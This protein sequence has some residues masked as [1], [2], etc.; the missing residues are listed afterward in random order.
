MHLCE[1]V[2]LR[3][4]L[5]TLV[6]VHA[7]VGLP[8]RLMCLLC[9]WVWDGKKMCIPVLCFYVSVDVLLSVSLSYYALVCA[10]TGKSRCI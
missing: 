7:F 4:L 6:Y 5:A 2:Y 3:Y 1:R 10:Q 8:G 9:C